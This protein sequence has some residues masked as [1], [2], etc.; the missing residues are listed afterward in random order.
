MEEDLRLPFF[1]IALVLLAL[2][3]LTE[4]GSE[5]GSQLHPTNPIGLGIP[6]LVLVDGLLFYMMMLMAFALFL[7]ER[8]HGLLQGIVTFIVSLIAT[9][10]SLAMIFVAL[11]ALIGMVTLLLATPFGT[12]AYFV[13]FGHFARSD[14]R[15]ELSLIMIL[16]LFF[17][18]CLVLAQQRFLQNKLLVF[19]IILALVANVVVSFLHGLVPFFLVSITDAL[20]AIVLAVLGLILAVILLLRSIPAVIKAIV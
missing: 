9:L 4:V 1:V 15:I 6:Y 3:V 8:L 13:I 14:A 7:P 10:S 17:A 18:G 11:F 5:I 16:K 20:A 2:A 12:A 19:T